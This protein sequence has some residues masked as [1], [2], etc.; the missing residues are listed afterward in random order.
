ME[1]SVNHLTA[2]ARKEGFLFDDP[3][4]LYGN[5]V[6]TRTPLAG[7]Y[8]D[9]LPRL[10]ALKAKVDPKNVMGLTGGFKF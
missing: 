6:N 3:P 9:N 8:G 5:Y 4:V 10:Q 7:I 1:E 2:I